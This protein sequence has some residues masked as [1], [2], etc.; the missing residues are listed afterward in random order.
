MITDL[1][2]GLQFS[3]NVKIIIHQ[4]GTHFRSFVCQAILVSKALI[5]IFLDIY[6]F[7]SFQTK[8]GEKLTPHRRLRSF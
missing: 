7:D 1:K 4:T 3:E 6:E 5:F 8:I 2:T